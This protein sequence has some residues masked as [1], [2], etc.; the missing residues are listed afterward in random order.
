M[1]CV[2]DLK[3]LRRIPKTLFLDQINCSQQIAT[4][5]IVLNTKEKTLTMRCIFP[6][7]C[8][9]NV[10]TAAAAVGIIIVIKG[11]IN[12]IIIILIY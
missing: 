9:P 8:F 12:M 11:I 10:T 5:I 4:K 6:Y 3:Q 1:W 2:S 7:C